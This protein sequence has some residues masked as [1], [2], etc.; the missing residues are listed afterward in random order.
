[1]KHT[2][3]SSLRRGLAA[4]ALA[5]GALTLA[6]A[7]GP[8]A[9]AGAG[10]EVAKAPATVTMQFKRGEFS[11][12]GA[13][14]VRAGRR[15]RIRNNTNPR[16]V[17]PHTFTLVRK[18]LL[19]DTR[20]EQRQCFTPGKICL[21]GATAHEFDEETEQ[22]GRPLVKAGKRGWDRP[23]GSKR[24]GDSW[25]TEAADE[26]FAQRVSARPGRTLYYM[27]IIHPEMQGKI[28]VLRRR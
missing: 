12:S 20:K 17:G 27:C 15:L 28:K 11:F 8:A 13:K 1:M 23:F 22:I 16:M 21:T 18:A 14:R 4:A 9:S 2:H 5:G 24:K 3:K 19:P 7:G 25:Y 10:A 26:T 6:L